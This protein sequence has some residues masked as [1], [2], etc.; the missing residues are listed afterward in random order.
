MAYKRFCDGCN[1][2]S[3]ICIITYEPGG[4][5]RCEP[6]G[7]QGDGLERHLSL[8]LGNNLVEL[9]LCVKCHMKVKSLLLEHFP[10][11][12]HSKS[13]LHRIPDLRID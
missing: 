7:K 12:S 3:P 6:C 8:K 2:E 10:A 11:L 13:P 4:N 1:L 9:E 5:S